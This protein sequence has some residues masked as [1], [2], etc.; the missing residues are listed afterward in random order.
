MEKIYTVKEVSSLLKTNVN[1][2]YNLINSGELMSIKIGS[3]KIRET[4]LEKYIN[5][6]SLSNLI[7]KRNTLS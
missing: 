7:V 3:T 2:V 4:D 6:L 5:S 1:Y